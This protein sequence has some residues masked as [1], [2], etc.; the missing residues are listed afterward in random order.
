[1]FSGAIAVMFFALNHAFTVWRYIWPNLIIIKVVSSSPANGEVYLIQHY[2]IKFV[3]DLIQ[4]YVIKFVSD[5]IQ[6]YVIK[7]DY[8]NTATMAPV[9]LTTQ[10]QPQWPLCISNALDIINN[11]ISK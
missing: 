2:V 1:M 4:H 8:T 3:S 7:F 6:H 9:K 10:T 11:F 5:L